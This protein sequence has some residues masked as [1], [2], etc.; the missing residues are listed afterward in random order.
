MKITD[1]LL[2][3]PLVNIPLFPVFIIVKQWEDLFFLQ[4]FF[5][6]IVA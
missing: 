3:I 5:E 4:F 2:D 1:E 6:K